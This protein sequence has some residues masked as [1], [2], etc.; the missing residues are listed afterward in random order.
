MQRLHNLIRLAKGYSAF[1]GFLGLLLGIAVVY[2]RNALSIALFVSISLVLTLLFAKKGKRYLISYLLCFFLTLT[3]SLIARFAI[4]YDENGVFFDGIVLEAKKNYFIFLSKGKRYIVYE[5]GPTREEGDILSISGR[6]LGLSISHQEGRFDFES[7]LF[8]KGVEREISPSSIECLFERPL[9]IRESEIR[10]LSN[11]DTETASLLDSLLFGQ[12]ASD[13][14]TLNAASSIGLFV[15]LST[16]GI[17]FGAL[18]RFLLWLFSLRGA[19]KTNDIYVFLILSVFFPFGFHKIGIRR[20]YFGSIVDALCALLKKKKPGMLEKNAGIG[21][22]LWLIDPFITFQNGFLLGYGLSFYL[23]AL[24]EKIKILGDK[25]TKRRFFSW[26]FIS[27]F[28]FPLYMEKG[29]FNFLSPF[30]SFLFPP[31]V[32][33]FSAIGYFGYFLTPNVSLITAYSSFLRSLF[34]WLEEIHVAIPIYGFAPYATPLYYTI[35]FVCLFLSEHGISYIKDGIVLTSL[36]VFLLS[37]LP[38]TNHFTY[39]VSFIDVG[40]GDS[41][42]IRSGT[43]CVLVDTGGDNRF[44]IAKEV[45]IPF[46][47]KKCIYK[48]DALILTHD[49]FDHSGGA[50]SLQKEFNVKRTISEKSSFP[51]TIGNVVFSSL[52]DKESVESNKNQGSIVLSFEIGGKDFLL[53]GDADVEVEKEIIEKRAPECDILKIGHHGSKTSTSEAF[54]DAVTPLE[55]IISCGKNNK[56]GHP[57]ASVVERLNKKGIKIRRTDLEGTIT[58][59]GYG[60][61]GFS[62]F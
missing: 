3:V 54:L 47:R 8:Y 9:R 26:L 13:S 39:E 21:T 55:A 27:L 62:F 25:R 12:S 58:Y 4:K 1:H 52:N 59:S 50:T 42:L 14:E 22:F 33:P 32:M 41:I 24:R 38:I 34:L 35:V 45:L 11:F 5:S 23:F 49:D 44:D 40:Q 19:K 43:S 31:L 18:K 36:L 56:Y 6:C 60:K 61:N 2:Q 30:A 15:T 46:L 10:Y 17:Y 57:D 48:L 29:A 53:M 37:F 28:L 7:Y 16:S 20:N 51:L